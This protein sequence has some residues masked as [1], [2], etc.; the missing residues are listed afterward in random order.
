VTPGYTVLVVAGRGFST[1][2][3]APALSDEG[4]ELA[5]AV[6]RGEALS[7]A[8]K[9]H[10]FAVVLDSG[11]VRFSCKRFC[12][13]LRDTQARIP[14]IV[15][16]PREVRIDRT[17]RARA[18]LRHPVSVNRLVR[19]L[20]QLLPTPD[21][22]VLRLHGVS[23]NTRQRWVMVGDREATLTPRQ[24]R[25][26]EVFMRHPGEVLT[27]AYLMK[28]VWKTDYMGDTRTL[29]VHIH[30]VRRAIEEDPGSP[31]L[32]V[33]VRGLGYRLEVPAEEAPGK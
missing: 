20:A 9:L 25:L 32:L 18:H 33:T 3:L 21:D 27:R 4:F 17:L 16:L 10:P 23:L 22:E 12:E 15:L 7:Q 6:T 5:K 31:A 13:A 14:V 1:E 11:S 19:R 28:Q 8:E 26:L 2:R 30:W 29:D 24:V